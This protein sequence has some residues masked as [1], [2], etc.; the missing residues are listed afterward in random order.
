M[1]RAFNP[2][3]DS[4]FDPRYEECGEPAVTESGLGDEQIHYRKLAA[5]QIRKRRAQRDAALRQYEA[6]PG[7]G[8]FG[9]DR[10]A[11]ANRFTMPPRTRTVRDALDWL[12]V[13][14]YELRQ[15]WKERP[16]R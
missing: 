1:N 9:L 4:P 10:E 11:P 3:K 5:E 7:H 13:G 12:D 6:K 14:L 15:W 8:F 2:M 16:W